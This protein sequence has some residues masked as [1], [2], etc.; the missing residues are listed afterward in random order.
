MKIA[1]PTVRTLTSTSNVARMR[2]ALAVV[3]A[4]IMIALAT[5]VRSWRSNEGAGPGPTASADAPATIVCVTE[6]RKVCD[7]LKAGRPWLT[8][9]V[10]DAG[11]TYTTITA[12]AFDPVAA[13][14]DAW[15][16]PEPWPTMVDEA[17]QRRGASPIFADG[18]KPLARSPLVIAVWNDRY[19]ALERR[20]GAEP[21]WRCIGEVA[22][23]PWAEVDASATW[24]GEV[25]PGIALPPTSAEGLL[26]AGQASAAYFGRSDIATNDFD[27]EFRRWFEQL[28]DAA[29]SAS[30][31]GAGRPPLDQ[32][33][34]IG[35]ATYDLAGTTEASAAAISTGRDSANIRII[36]PSPSATADI[37]P[38][39]FTSSASASRLTA[40]LTSS[41]VGGI[42]A[43]AGWRVNDQS[44]PPT[45]GLPRSGVLEDLRTRWQETTR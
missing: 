33:L 13:K 44:L 35:R 38:A 28:A 23:R 7:Q 12:A 20:C 16:V 8:V 1:W 43:N 42:F 29:T 24:G 11:R 21:G 4:V 39:V 9:V 41:E 31:N 37:V 2:R 14:L 18:R 34:S 26:I 17:R 25:K 40:A 27:E 15:I 5:L 22:G 6:L 36:Y 19:A 10:E 30:A 32:M 45:N 3:A